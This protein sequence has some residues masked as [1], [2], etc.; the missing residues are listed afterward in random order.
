MPDDREVGTEDAAKRFEGGVG[1]E[2][3]VGPGEVSVAVA[4]HNGEAD[5]GY[6]AGA[7]YHLET[8]A[9]VV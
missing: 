7:A 3:D 5:G 4:E 2:R 1:A 6:Y 9:G 8:V